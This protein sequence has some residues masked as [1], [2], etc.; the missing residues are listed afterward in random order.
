MFHIYFKA[1]FVHFV[2]L[3]YFILT[4][5]NVLTQKIETE[6]IKKMNVKGTKKEYNSE[7]TA[8]NI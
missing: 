5:F 6:N 8:R 4:K 7:K 3:I 1:Y 2:N